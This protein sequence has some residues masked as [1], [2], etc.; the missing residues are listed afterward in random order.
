M[1]KR[2][3]KNHQGFRFSHRLAIIFM[4]WS[5][6]IPAA[7]ATDALENIKFQHVGSSSDFATPTGFAIVNFNANWQS[8]GVLVRW[9]AINEQGITGYN[10]MRSTNAAG[11][12]MSTVTPEPITTGTGTYQILDKTAVQGQTY[13]YWIEVLP[14][15]LVVGPF[16]ATKPGKAMFPSIL[17]NR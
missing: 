4:L 15:G 8:N 7:S 12:D 6:F 3:T 16:A 11:T 9:T 13:F 2:Q 14:D 10:V 1:E 5:I 17:K